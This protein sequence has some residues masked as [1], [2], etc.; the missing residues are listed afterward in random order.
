MERA[1][2]L[3]KHLLSRLAAIKNPLVREVRGRGLF[4]GIELDAKQGSAQTVWRNG[5]CAPES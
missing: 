3:G 2:A 1:A 4:A 5:Y